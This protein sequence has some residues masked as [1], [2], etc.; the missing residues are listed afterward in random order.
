MAAPCGHLAPNG[1]KSILYDQLQAKY[2]ESKAHDIWEAIR[3][4]Q[5][6]NK[7]GNWIDSKEVT[8]TEALRKAEEAWA[9]NVDDKGFP[10]ESLQPILKAIN[11]EYDAKNNNGI[12]LDANGEPTTEWVESILGIKSIMF[13][14]EPTTG[15]RNRTIK[16]ASADAT[17]AIA[18]DFS[19]AGERLTHN[20][21]IN[22]G[23]KYIPLDANSFALLLR[24]E[25]IKKI[26]DDLNSV[27]AK[28]LNIAGNGIYTMKGAYTQ[29]QVDAFTQKLL[30]A[31]TEHPDLKNKIESLRT[32]GQTGFD[33]AGTKAGVALGIPTR[34]L[35][36]K[37][38][39]FRDITG[40]DISSETEF[41]SRFG[42]VLSEM[43][44]EEVITDSSKEVVTIT[45]TRDRTTG[46]IAEAS[47]LAQI[48]AIY[49]EALAN[50][51]KNYTIPYEYTTG[52]R[53]NELGYTA[54]K[55][56]EMLTSFEVP[57]NV[58]INPGLLALTRNS[59]EQIA[60][61]F[62]NSTPPEFIAVNEPAVLESAIQLLV[63]RSNKDGERDGFFNPDDQADIVNAI[64]T[65]TQR[66]YSKDP[67][68]K[69]RSI[70]QVMK[71]L[72][73]KTRL[74]QDTGSTEMADV[75]IS[76][77]NARVQFAELALRQLRSLGLKID[78]PSRT[79]ILDAIDKEAVP[80]M[81]VQ[82]WAE[83]TPVIDQIDATLEGFSESAGRIVRD[84]SE[85]TFELDP[86]DTAS[87]RIKM[88]M[89]TMFAM[90]RG[91]YKISTNGEQIE[92]IN[93]AKLTYAESLALAKRLNR[94]PFWY[95]DAA[96]SEK[97]RVLL[98]QNHPRLTQ[99]N[100]M[101]LPKVA[102]YNEMFRKTLNL[103]G[104]KPQNSEFKDFMA[105]LSEHPDPTMQQ[106]A[107]ELEKAD[108]SMKNEFMTVMMKQYQSFITGLFNRVSEPGTRK[109]Y[110]LNPINSNRYGQRNA[111]INYWKE[112]QKLSELTILSPTGDRVLDTERIR[113]EWGP[114]LTK[115][116]SIK[117]WT[118][119]EN[120]A[121]FIE[122]M[123]E[124]FR[125]SG[126]EIP[127]QMLGYMYMYPRNWSNDN[128]L[129]GLFAT[130]Q[131]GEP[132]GSM[133]TFIMKS[134]G[135]TG[136][137]DSSDPLE[138]TKLSQLNNPLYTETSFMRKIAKLYT[139]Y[140]DEMYSSNHLNSKGRNI[141]D[142]GLNTKLSHQ[143][144]AFSGTD[145]SF[146]K[147]AADADQ[148]YIS[149]NNWLIRTL[150]ENPGQ[151]Q[152][153]ELNYLD[154]LKPVW[155]NR[156]TDRQEMSDR[157]QMVMAIT[158]FQN[159]GHGFN[160]NSKVNY[161]SLTHADK[162]MT[163][164]FRNIP[165][166]NTGEWNKMPNNI[167]GTM[168]SAMYNVFKSEYDRIVNH[169]GVDFNN[170]Q[171]DKGKGLFYLLPDFNYDNMRKMAE[172]GTLTTEEFH[173]L[174]PAGQKKLTRVLDSA[175]EL[176]VINKILRSFALN[177][178]V[179]TLDK[180]KDNKIV[181]EDN[182]IFDKTYVAKLAVRNGIEEVVRQGRKVTD[183]P[184]MFR[185][186]TTKQEIPL[187]DYVKIISTAAAKDY[188][189]NSFLFNTT[190]S[191]LFYGDP[192]E[193]FKASKAKDATDMDHV[194]STL[195]E[196]NKRLAKDIAPRADLYW[197]PE[198][199][200][201]NTLTLKD[202]ETR[203]TYL[204]D[205]GDL[206]RFY[207]DSTTTS[208]DAQEITTVQEKLDVLYA[209]GQISAKNHSEMS[210]IIS[211][212]GSGGYYEFV[213]PDHRA[214]I[215]QPEKPLYAGTGII[216]K[217]AKLTNYVKSSAWA[218]YPPFTK[219][220]QLD[221][222]RIL[223]EANNIQR[224]NYES[225]G[226][227][228]NTAQALEVFNAEGVYTN[229]TPQQLQVSVQKFSRDGFGIQQEVP[230]DEGKESIKTLTQMNEGI[231]DGITGIKGFEI[232]GY[233]PMTGREV[234]A[235]KEQ[236]RK[237]LLQ[238]NLDRLK[239]RL[240]I[241]ESGNIDPEIVFNILE[242]EVRSDTRNS[243][244]LNEL[245]SIVIRD[246]DGTPMIPLTF[247]TA[248]DKFEG[249][250]MSIINK[251]AD[252]KVPG[253]SYVQASGTGTRMVN[254]DSTDLT[255]IIRI[256]NWN[257]SP[258]KTLRI[259]D[260]VV[261]PAQ[262]ILPFNFYDNKGNKLRVADFLKE[263]TNELDMDRVPVELLQLTGGRIPNQGHSSMLPIEIVGF[264]PDN[265]G[266]IVFIPGAVVKQMGA[267]FDV[268]KLY[269]YKRPYNYNQE[270]RAF[271][272]VS[273]VKTR[274]RLG[275]DD[276]EWQG[277]KVRT[278]ELLKTAGQ[279]PNASG[280]FPLP[281]FNQHLA[282]AVKEK[283]GDSEVPKHV[284]TTEVPRGSQHRQNDY[285]NIHWAILTHPDMI[286]R[287]LRPLD[288]EDLK[289]ESEKL[290]PVEGE[291]YNFFDP[292]TQLETFQ[293][294]KDA[295]VLV[296]LTSWA[297]KFNQRI[298][299]KNLRISKAQF[300]EDSKTLEIVQ[301]SILLKDEH[302]GTE[303]ELVLLSGNGVGY[304]TESDKRGELTTQQRKVAA[305]TKGNNHITAQSESV[306][307]AKNRTL[308]NLNLTPDTYRAAQALIQLQTEEGWAPSS[309]YW[310]RLLTQPIIWE[311][312]KEMKQGNDSFSEK[313]DPMLF[314]TVIKKLRIKYRDSVE[315]GAD[316]AADTV[317]D[318]QTLMNARESEGKDFVKHQLSA[319][320]LFEK[321]YH[322][323]RRMFDLEA[324]FNQD[325]GGA[326][327]N[328][329]TLM[330]KERN[331]EDLDRLPIMNAYDI[332]R[333]PDERGGV[334]KTEVGF[335]FD[336]LNGTGLEIMGQVFPYRN[337]T[338]MMDSLKVMTNR[339]SLNMD[340][341]KSFLRAL[342]SS[343]F[344]TGQHWW[345]DAQIER[346]RLIYGENSLAKRVARAQ[347][348]W[349]KANP[350]F[351]GL[352]TEIADNDKSP[353]FVTYKG[354]NKATDTELQGMSTG[355]LD[356]LLSPDVEHRILGEDLIR[357]AYLSGG[358]PDSNSFVKF[359]PTSFIANTEFA[360]ML[361]DVENTI[362]N[363]T[364]YENY[365]LLVQYIQH[366]PD[367]ATGL[368]QKHFG[369]MAEGQEYPEAFRIPD[370]N[371]KNYAD[372]T[373][374]FGVD[375]MLVPFASYRSRSDGRWIL[376]MKDH[377]D[378]GTYYTR[379]DT[380]GNE[381]MDEYNGEAVAG[382]RSI[383]EDN[384]SLAEK[385]PGLEPLQSIYDEKRD[386]GYNK[387][388]SYFH[389]IGIREGGLTELNQALD[390]IRENMEVP[391]YLRTV[392]NYMMLT[393]ETVE[394]RAAKAIVGAINKPFLLSYFD[395]LGV[396]GEAHF[397]NQVYLNPE[398]VR[399]QKEAAEVTLHELIHNRLQFMIT[400]TGHDRRV[401][402]T[403]MD[404]PLSKQVQKMID[405][406][407][408][409]FPQVAK[410]IEELERVRYEGYNALRNRLGEDRFHD[411][412]AEVEAGVSNTPEHDLVYAMMSVQEL[413]AHVM[414]NKPTIEFLNSVTDSKGTTVLSRIWEKLL[415][416]IASVGRAL[417]IVI[418][419]DSL[420]KT[421]LA[422]TLKLVDIQ[423]AAD[424]NITQHLVTG[425]PAV[426]NTEKQARELE[427]LFQTVY[428]RETG[429]FTNGLQWTITNQARRSSIPV[430]GQRG[431]ILEQL[432]KQLT[433]VSDNR[434]LSHDINQRVKLG[435]MEKE[436][437]E[438]INMIHQSTSLDVI[439]EIGKKQLEWV[440]EVLSRRSPSDI[441]IYLALETANIW[442]NMTEIMYGGLNT[443]ADTSEDFV[444]LENEATKR[445]IVLINDK[446]RRVLSDQYANRVQLT[447]M[448][449]K[450][451]LTDIDGLSA[452]VL[453]LTR[454]K[455]LL[456]QA[457]ALHVWQ[458][459]N[460]KDEHVQRNTTELYKLK[461]QMDKIGMKGEDMLQLDEDGE[462]WTLINRYSPKWYSHMNDLRY[463]L[464]QSLEGINKSPNLKP[465]E[466]SEKRQKIWSDYWASVR[467]SSTMVDTRTFFGL[468][469]GERLSGERVDKAMADLVEQVGSEKYA[470]ELV[471]KA[472]DQYQE[473]ITERE[474][475]RD[476]IDATVEL[477]E[478]EKGEKTLEELEAALKTKREETMDRWIRF[479]SPLELL[480]KLE[481]GKDIRFES[482]GDQWI[483]MVPVRDNKDFFDEKFSRIENDDR[484]REVYN[485]YMALYKEMVSYL[486]VEVQDQIPD[487]H[488]PVV[489]KDTANWLAR[490]FNKIRNWDSHALN[491]LTA[492]D[493]EEA[494]RIRPD[495]IP[496][497]YIRPR[498]ITKDI[499]QRSTDPIRVLEA[500]SM[501]ALQHKYMGN[502]LAT[503]N[504]A[505]GVLK[506]VNKRRLE[507][508]EEGKPL[509]HVMDALRYLKESLVFKKPLAL[510]GKIDNKIYSI[511]PAKQHKIQKQIKE[512][513]GQRTVLE[514]EMMD[515][516]LEGDYTRVDEIQGK[517]DAINEKLTEFEKDARNIYGSKVADQ[518]ISIN[519]MK[520][521]YYNPF[522]AVA[523][524]SFAAISMGVYARGR[525]DY[526]PE[527]LRAATAVMTHSMKKYFMFADQGDAT[528]QKVHALMARAGMMGDVVD[529]DYGRS[530]LSRRGRSKVETA[531]A[532]MNWQRSGD[533]FNKGTLMVAM[534]KAKKI[535][536]IE[537]VTGTEVEI[538]VWDAMDKDGELDEKYKPNEA[539]YSVDV[540]KQKDWMNFRDKM[541]MVNTMI[542]GNQDKNAPLMAKKNWLGRMAGQFRMS[543]FPEGI[544]S[545]FKPEY[546]DIALGRTNKGRWVTIPDIGIATSGLILC[547]QL[548][549]ALPGVKMNPFEGHTLKDGRA[550]TESAIDM[551]NMR[552]NFAGL[553]WTVSIAALILALR[554][555]AGS[556][557]KD[558]DD[559]KRQ[560]LIN[561]LIRNQQDL[562][563]YSS[564]SVFNTISGN[565]L[566][567]TQV[568][569]DY[570]NA[571]KASGH[572]MFGN[573]ERERD[574]FDKWIRKIAKAGLPH[575]IAT[576]Y[577]KINT[578]MTRDLDKL[579]R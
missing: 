169:E 137:R 523:N 462:N 349:G 155:G 565:F 499:D 100:V 254:A 76:V 468:E 356:L 89:G 312:S 378:T 453:A 527:D 24:P 213:N 261:K 83:D 175:R 491:A 548:L 165:K 508:Q 576:Q 97:L 9:H 574:A 23:K 217:G 445:R 231:V 484:K 360:A 39:K 94:K 447:P 387:D 67:A 170:R 297:V 85:N 467:K 208:T 198:K 522:S 71:L 510:Q 496:V 391:E 364:D 78:A 497:M 381:F 502:V 503:I 320:N 172:D 295:R 256:G 5:F 28:T 191:Q 406:Y 359:A 86:K 173:A 211:E 164:V 483:T 244:T 186:T 147:F 251:V 469:K 315:N 348:T 70:M 554:S 331:M 452:N 102:D 428:N 481:S 550:L 540:S 227:M 358:I 305:R 480:A 223:M 421:A 446:S 108:Q 392:A 474:I 13:E 363:T 206:K 199:R 280:R 336:A 120:R 372:F 166:L 402:S 529:T 276:A 131:A 519:Q 369:E 109:G 99:D 139:R 238:D 377:I 193:T 493:V 342:R 156:G 92:D 558:E 351:S 298:Q 307:N 321:L 179:N 181:T 514:K 537:A 341:Q 247:N 451:K 162:T 327:R 233:G 458:Q 111:L 471:E 51:D 25:S 142:W 376:Y 241:D 237:E 546:Y 46:R 326:G 454:A 380:L 562:M 388:V 304:Y 163:P 130:N 249:L 128:S 266:D 488:F 501:M 14:E 517:I 532:P 404:T 437:R 268:D 153:M 385:L 482:H 230:Y 442:S 273:S 534:L 2:G 563:L 188:A 292:M 53:K 80:G 438:Q 29:Q 401:F 17:I 30:K 271:E 370:T 577:G 325:V 195:I 161:M 492:T 144:R 338:S 140:R 498:G 489:P 448:D 187:E 234:K 457:T 58:H 60:K 151:V 542:F 476:H 538:S 294:G 252:V 560:L 353:D 174:W 122:K 449:F 91:V 413:V 393:K 547:K 487:N 334:A 38:W 521:L 204:S 386:S 228:G 260:G 150:R 225:A 196:Y 530:N 116:Q 513:I 194:R 303:R 396:A 352:K 575:P 79:R 559:H 265:M 15:Y 323:G 93:L 282:E 382:Q 157:E 210:T 569:T 465:E 207:A 459:A 425:E 253:K 239:R 398:G 18:T 556:G 250:L 34:I 107:I 395:K 416:M 407:R 178:V 397:D 308:D 332:Y 269:T 258:L 507:G 288:Q 264:V 117:D 354:S 333:N 222:L 470:K 284:V 184:T 112:Q 192:A 399:S 263:G 561:M 114:I 45:G 456:V 63:P 426:V 374:L 314:D 177:L 430:V 494:L 101:G 573:T 12:P 243:Y 20:A 95:K 495:K 460:N 518:L 127:E 373:D 531:L 367:L 553:A 272:P 410:H 215:M 478:E 345:S 214:I 357:Y 339:Q 189:I 36:P 571:M 216:N 516:M 344:T 310:T 555:M 319:L 485:K 568:L 57:A 209:A 69:D 31:V 394:G 400:A 347:K 262:A 245:Q 520:A 279:K 152:D 444:K 528:A 64:V 82:E 579:Y 408:H 293:S 302:T 566:P 473:Y 329:F 138:R 423:A 133:S 115:A 121:W 375:G 219:G 330:D 274:E 226:K 224:A 383:F 171:Y 104:N 431:R 183:T 132:V 159:N 434:S 259:E 185:D 1:E 33:E 328:L 567:A 301:D 72:S 515:L 318:P 283:Y 441:D 412:Q 16:N 267:D 35:A 486:P 190:L 59:A 350:L 119:P 361:K 322:I 40:R 415:D 145:V 6:L 257:G 123:G 47:V 146:N 248:A 362:K 182:M 418:K 270:T 126:I 50:P 479:N 110:V 552:K 390:S 124:I 205:I 578:M 436:I 313:Y 212:A 98:E 275:A 7:H 504:L 235:L 11:E 135:L 420:L 143:F 203:D 4:Q 533:Y 291:Y 570:W 26:V 432:K 37:G 96:N 136:N 424:V 81:E 52:N 557:E 129:E 472:H 365:G 141:W 148:V 290:K 306:D 311:F 8:R 524:Y 287:V 286:E 366:N 68:M 55:M 379:I 66:L 419:D 405:D 299:D 536:L 506:D 281:V 220:R 44:T 201:Y 105:L 309:K 73:D 346:V 242:E 240:N 551:E 160:T 168:D 539:W 87:A 411:I 41:K 176:P 545:R 526:S 180:W 422:N 277:L 200:M 572:Y 61:E 389:Q 368:M 324:Q 125:L 90:D 343:A 289:Q 103:L 541:R 512:L 42:D 335:T 246:T 62:G 500:F 337:L 417:G 113:R 340:Q 134:G 218:L 74:L 490:T 429:V 56:S 154:G 236:V 278:I 54:R 463:R 464:D 158:L 549:A 525:T 229:P 48:E 535:K 409:Q 505:E 197:A 316:I 10:K 84:W 75:Y 564:P 21:V 439:T 167:I 355:W 384:R 443:V 19:S 440:D 461:E 475:V 427:Q 202:V 371:A 296:G 118:L 65:A 455:P 543:W 32:G 509:R 77:H 221:G 300:N 511:N 49:A 477:T 450:E 3:S 414:T 88:F 255:G 43:P 544:A 232:A 435:L 403:D 317:F 106:M 27:N 466:R 285:F 22:Q 433:E 149:R